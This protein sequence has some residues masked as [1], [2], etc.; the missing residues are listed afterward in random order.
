MS[1]RLTKESEN[2]KLQTTRGTKREKKFPV[3]DKSN[4]DPNLIKASSTMSKKSSKSDSK[5]LKGFHSLPGNKHAAAPRD[6]GHS[7]S[8][9]SN[10]KSFA[11]SFSLKLGGGSIYSQQSAADSKSAAP[12]DE[13]DLTNNTALFDRNLDLYRKFRVAV[14]D[15]E[16]LIQSHHDRAFRRIQE[17]VM[18]E[19]LESRI[20]VENR[21]LKEQSLSVKQSFVLEADVAKEDLEQLRALQLYHQMHV[22]RLLPSWFKSLNDCTVCIASN[23]H[24]DKLEWRSKSRK[25]LLLALAEMEDDDSS[26]VVRAKV[27]YL[28]L[29]I[30]ARKAQ[31]VLGILKLIREEYIRHKEGGSELGHHSSELRRVKDL[32]RPDKPC[33]LARGQWSTDLESSAASIRQ[34]H[35][36]G[37]ITQSA[38]GLSSTV[39]SI[40]DDFTLASADESLFPGDLAGGEALE[41]HNSYE[42]SRMTDS[43]SR[44]DE[45]NPSSEVVCPSGGGKA[46]SRFVLSASSTP[47]DP[48]NSSDI[49]RLLREA[50]SQGLL[51]EAWRVFTHFYGEYINNVKDKVFLHMNLKCVPSLDTFKLL[52]MAFKN[53]DSN[54]FD[55]ISTILMLM[56]RANVDPDLELF[57][58]ILRSCERRGAWRRALKY[59]KVACLLVSSACSEL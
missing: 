25:L 6:D 14:R 53:S 4:R 48:H 10:S 37:L 15:T 21:E 24:S 50:A 5:V 27:R 44:F 45:E 29:S 11:S 28:A 17:R 33:P 12:R 22:Q 52:N 42:F 43:H 35:T 47:V 23:G 38:L 7:V 39:Q 9:K 51:Q 57:N 2:N 41:A 1:P 40:D 19:T 30:N 8:A 18:K 16:D 36:T 34:R 32:L 49:T 58:M 13:S 20:E 46:L 59:L 26:A 56:K 54:Q 3:D 31:Q 55:D